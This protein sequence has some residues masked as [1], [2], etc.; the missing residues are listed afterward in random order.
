MDR[1]EFLPS[2]LLFPALFNA[3]VKEAAGADVRDIPTNTRKVI[4]VKNFGAGGDGITDDSAAIQNAIDASAG[5]TIYFPP[6]TY[7]VNA[8]QSVSYT[9]LTLPTNREVYISVSAVTL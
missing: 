3:Y 9:H 7:I 2:L 1:R 8:L 6:G 4:S 5:K